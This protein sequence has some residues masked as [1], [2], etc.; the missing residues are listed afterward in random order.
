[1]TIWSTYFTA[2]GNILW[3]FGIFCGHLV[4]FFPFWYFHHEK[5]GNPAYGIEIESLL[6]HFGESS[7]TNGARQ[8]ADFRIVRRRSVV[9]HVLEVSAEADGVKVVEAGCLDELVLADDVAQADGTRARG[10]VAF[11]E[12]LLKSRPADILTGNSDF[13]QPPF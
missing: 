5:S 1:M 10:N 11:G 3:P 12:E 9:V 2:I 4:Y 8:R 13:D 6:F 7:A